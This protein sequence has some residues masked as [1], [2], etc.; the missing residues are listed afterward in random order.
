MTNEEKITR[1]KWI[2]RRISVR[3]RDE[4]RDFEVLEAVIKDIETLSNIESRFGNVF[5]EEDDR[6][7]AVNMFKELEARISADT[8]LMAVSG[9]SVEELTE[10]FTK[11]YRLVSPEKNN[12]IPDMRV[13]AEEA[14]EALQNLTKAG[15]SQD[16][17]E[18]ADQI[19][20]K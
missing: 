12:Q 20:D 16:D 1:L 13:T 10:A 4:V 14:A 18:S 17:I 5:E 7:I 6:L 9:M 8:R 19:I 2:Q 11:G 3:T 15:I